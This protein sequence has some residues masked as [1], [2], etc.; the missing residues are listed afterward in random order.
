M[1]KQFKLK[2]EAGYPPAALDGFFGLPSVDSLGCISGRWLLEDCGLLLRTLLA[3][4]TQDTC[5]V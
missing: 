2:L 1:S 4:T 5:G 3:L